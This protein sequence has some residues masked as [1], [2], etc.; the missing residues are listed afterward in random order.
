MKIN[1]LH[2]IVIIV[3]IIISHNL[4][5]TSRIMYKFLD[6]HS[7]SFANTSLP[8]PLLTYNLPCTDTIPARALSSQ[9]SPV[10]AL[11]LRCPPS[12]PL[13]DELLLTMNIGLGVHDVHF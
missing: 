8:T 13:P 6:C 9:L 5:K 1:Q 12:I 7:R 10:Q 11:L 4:L 2:V 3:I